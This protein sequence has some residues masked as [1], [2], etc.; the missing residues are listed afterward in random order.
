M[1]LLQKENKEEHRQCAPKFNKL[2]RLFSLSWLTSCVSAFLLSLGRIAW[3]GV[4]AAALVGVGMGMGM[5]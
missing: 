5:G 4:M 3:P 1:H 2:M